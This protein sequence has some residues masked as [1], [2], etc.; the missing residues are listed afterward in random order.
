MVKIPW[1]TMVYHGIP[2]YFFTRDELFET[3]ALLLV[4][5]YHNQMNSNM[6]MLLHIRLRFVNNDFKRKLEHFGKA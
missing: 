1:F 2:W 6:T 4:Q 5:A 3:T